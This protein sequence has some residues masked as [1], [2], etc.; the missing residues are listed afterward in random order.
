MI[1]PGRGDRGQA[2]V[3]LALV[4]PLVVLLGLLVAQVGV[5]VREQVLL[6]HATREAARAA[7]VAEGDR[8]VAARRGATLAGPLAA[9]R[10]TAEV[11]VD[12]GMVRVVTH[13]RSVTD[14]PLV[15][16]LVPDLDLGSSA[17]MRVESVVEDGP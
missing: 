4:L 11:S 10:L 14:L 9:D 12:A 7:A 16:A 5:V 13:Y 17:A 8:L 3:E 15:G 6:T 1:T 2:T